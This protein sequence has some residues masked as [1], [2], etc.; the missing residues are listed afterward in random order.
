M[1]KKTE[2]GK[3]KSVPMTEEEREH[4]MKQKAVAEEEVAKKKR[5][6]LTQ[7]LKVQSSDLSNF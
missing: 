2:K 6:M 3:G 5:V 4:Y 1:E 7:V